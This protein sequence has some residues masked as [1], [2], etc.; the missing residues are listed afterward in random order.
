V[1]STETP[2]EFRGQYVT[3]AVE[4]VVRDESGDV[5]G[6]VGLLD[7]DETD[8]EDAVSAARSL[9]GPVAVVRSSARSWHLWCLR[10]RSLEAWTE[11]ASGLDAVDDEHVALNT[12]RGVGVLR[13][14]PKVSLDDGEH[15]RPEPVLEGFVDVDADGPV[16]EPHG[17]VLEDVDAVRPRLASDVVDDLADPVGDSTERRT[18][19]AD[20]GG[21]DS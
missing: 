6:H 20:V 12:S 17:R 8:R 5:V 19:I 1:T 11:D 2:E 16:S 15:V 7:V 3:Q 9:P 10:V 18:F 4:S 13:V 14:G 21:V